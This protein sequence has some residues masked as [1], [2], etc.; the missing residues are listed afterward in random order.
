M[1]SSVPVDVTAVTNSIY[2]QI[3]GM[4]SNRA[5]TQATLI[6]IAGNCMELVE[7]AG[8][9]P[10]ATKKQIVLA[11]MSQLVNSIPVGGAVTSDIKA[12][13]QGT[14]ANVLPTVIDS[15]VNAANGNTSL[16]ATVAED[17]LGNNC[18]GSSSAAP[19]STSSSASKG[20]SRS[21]R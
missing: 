1:S 6:E 17:V 12:S 5:I 15:I 20:K 8:T 11:V 18:C 2:A 16:G 9:M 19:A 13:L 4:I 21:R 10:G 7:A 14:V 3:Q